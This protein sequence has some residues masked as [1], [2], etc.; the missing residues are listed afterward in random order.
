MS[1]VTV[2][3]SATIVRE[4]I[5]DSKAGES[6]KMEAKRE[7]GDSGSWNP[8]NTRVFD[9]YMDS[10]ASQTSQL[11][12]IFSCEDKNV[13]G[14]R[15]GDD[16]ELQNSGVGR[17]P[18]AFS[19]DFVAKLRNKRTKLDGSG[20]SLTLPIAKKE[21]SPTVS[22][23]SLASEHIALGQTDKW[24]S[25][26][27]SAFIAALRLIIKNGTSKFKIFD[28][29]YGRNELISLFVQYHTNEIRTKKQIS[30][31]IQVWKKSISNKIASNFKINDLDREIL[32]LIEE[33][34]PQTTESVKLFYST[35]EEIVSALVKNEKGELSS[36]PSDSTQRHPYLT[37]ASSSSV[38][39]L[40]ASS[41]AFTA[42]PLPPNSLQRSSTP[43]TPLEYAKSIYGNLKTYKCVPVK[44]QEQMAMQPGTKTPLQPVYGN[45]SQKEFN[46]PV[47]QSAKDLELQQRQLIENL[48]YSQNQLKLP[49]VS[50]D[51]YMRNMQPTVH[52]QQ[53]SLYRPSSRGLAA[54]PLSHY[55][56]AYQQYQQTLEH[57]PAGMVLPPHAYHQQPQVYVPISV[58]HGRA[59]N[60]N[61]QFARLPI[62]DLQQPR[63]QASSPSS[64]SS[65]ASPN[66]DH[67]HREPGTNQVNQT[68]Q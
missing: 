63:M 30:S 2:S 33:G 49:P 64:S 21:P 65:S 12:D 7:G 22:S 58:G 54:A 23:G 34:A 56:M 15:V 19:G 8:A 11:L 53:P 17:R 52:A 32:R 6:D 27:E 41:N 25:Q 36:S 13:K 26:M 20:P 66:D 5:A 9:V 3:S 35:F 18:E 10:G 51:L 37:P 59:N 45:Y 31:H 55:P 68:K 29:N 40:Y 61:F 67:I 38:N 48:S 4:D 60:G 44:V 39:T 50:P 47:L 62:N 28:K 46:N 42:Q 57:V 43:A 16:V 24:P 14:K 1:G